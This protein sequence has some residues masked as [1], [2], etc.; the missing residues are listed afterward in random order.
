MPA[1]KIL[2]VD[3]QPINVQL[4][5]RKLEREGMQVAA[6]YSGQEALD[7][8]QQ[9]KPELILLDVMMPEMDGI[10]VCQRLQAD[11]DTRSI[12]I[13]F[14]TARSSKEGKL[15]GLGVGAVDYITKPI[16][17]DETLA[18]V[19]TQLRFAAINREIIDLQR[20]LVETRRA[21]TIGAVTQG[22]A[23]NLNNLLGVVIGYLDLIKANYNKPELVKKNVQSVEDAV[24]RIV[25]IIRQLS[26]LVVKAKPPVVKVSL[27]KMLESGTERYHTEYKISQPVTINNSLGDLIIETHIEM[28][29]E[30]L[31]KVLV[32]AWEAYGSETPADRRPITVTAELVV[33]RRENERCVQIKVT[34]QGRGIDP[35][36]RDHMFEPFISSKHTVGVGM[37]LTV[38][39]HA[40][41]NIGGE[42]M[43]EDRPG[44]G[45]V[46]V[47]THPIEQK[48]KKK[49]AK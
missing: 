47:L 24:G 27:Q 7:L 39:R 35:D 26:S 17:L 19:Q 13:I 30:V 15:E 46:A 38:A 9:E 33:D 16:D 12:P 8:V 28:F 43:M 49:G 31:S 37:G 32:N 36:I 14:V 40:L 20:R 22:I 5:K 4:L 45:S 42:V 6:A 18:R 25:S 29:E 23:H 44:G 21:A 1:P 34:D 10:Q 48:Q 3:D 11:E 41:R 2:V